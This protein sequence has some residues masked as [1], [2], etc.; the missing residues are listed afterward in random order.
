MDESSLYCPITLEVMRDPVVASDGHTYEREAIMTWFSSGKDKS[1]STGAR[2]ASTVVLP[3]HRI[4][5]IINESGLSPS[6]SSSSLAGGGSSTNLLLPRSSSSVLSYSSSRDVHSPSSTSL[7][8]D[9][10]G[11][12]RSSSAGYAAVP[13]SSGLV[14]S[15]STHRL[16]PHL[17][18]LVRTTRFF[19]EYLEQRDQLE[20]LMLFLFDAQMPLPAELRTESGL[21]RLAT[22][23]L[24][25]SRASDADRVLREAMELPGASYVPRL[26]LS[27]ALVLR[28]D[29]D[30]AIVHLKD[31]LVAVPEDSPDYA[32]LQGLLETASGSED[33]HLSYEESIARAHEAHSALRIGGIGA[34]NA[35]LRHYRTENLA[36]LYHLHS[37][38]SKDD[39]VALEDIVSAQQL[40]FSRK[41]T[42]L[43]NT[44]L[45][46]MRLGRYDEALANI[47]WSLELSDTEPMS[48]EHKANILKRLNRTGEAVEC[49]T[50]VIRLKP[51]EAEPL[52]TRATVWP[53]A[54]RGIEDCLKALQLEPDSLYAQAMLVALF[55]DAGQF[56]DALDA[57]TKF[58][59]A[60]VAKMGDSAFR[61]TPN[62]AHI[63][64]SR[65][66][67]SL[68]LGDFQ[69][70]LSDLRRL[71]SDGREE[72][73][74]FEKTLEMLAG[75]WT[76][77]ATDA[78]TKRALRQVLQTTNPGLWMSTVP[79][80]L[81]SS[82]KET[83]I[84]WG[85]LF[86][87]A[88]KRYLDVASLIQVAQ[89]LGPIVN[90]MMTEG[91]GEVRARDL[92]VKLV[93]V[94][95]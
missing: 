53:S 66:H 16:Q 25:R 18:D 3:N 7:S 64:R 21:L 86:T 27:I 46:L 34:T 20:V 49:W 47:N 12:E 94:M 6:N 84:A 51:G 77:N 78:S 82:D 58:I 23:L 33:A 14:N 60:R 15:S 9:A 26:W 13:S 59:N 5:A 79:S 1:P 22:A 48:W 95:L 87:V 56:R 71:V 85:M 30:G 72:D 65:M 93:D 11:S 62:D 63:V 81:K 4:R 68:F 89:R 24:S 17:A 83:L 70:A 74:E 67:A 61:L 69:G 73:A 80:G 28:G 92:L 45:T 54:Q 32:M 35:S 38:E 41:A 31:L 55:L 76:S 50:R 39:H 75:I 29:Y 57:A 91:G 40:G 19:D 8:E 52:V 2:L 42:L 36:W 10:E 44:A 90:A 88:S 43:R 37:V